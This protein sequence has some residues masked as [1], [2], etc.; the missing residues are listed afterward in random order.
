MF[1]R[2]AIEQSV[3]ARFEEQVRR[4][5][6]R[7][8][9][10][11]GVDAWSY[12][13]LNARANQVAHAILDARS[14]PGETVAL[15]L[16]QGAGLVATILG[17]LKAG[18]IYVPLDPSLAPGRLA[19]LVADSRAPL[20]IGDARARALAAT[21]R[22]VLVAAELLAGAP[23]A[24]PGLDIAP[25]AGAYV[26]YTSGSTGRPKGVLDCHRNVLHNVM[27]Y[28][29]TLGITSADRLTLLQ[30]PAF[31]GAVSSLFAALLN[32][33]ASFPY[34]VPRNGVRGIAAWLRRGAITI[35]HSVPALFRQVVAGAEAFPDLRLVRLEGDTASPRDVELFRRR[36]APGAV[37][38]NGLGATECGIVRQLFVRDG[39]PIPARLLPVGYPVEDMEVVLIDDAGQECA[40]GEVGEIAVRSRYLATGYWQRPD[41]TAA[42][43]TTLR[44]G[45]RMYRTGDLGRMTPDG[46]LTHLGR[47]DF[48]AKIRG[49]RVEVAD[50]EAALLTMPAVKDA[51]VTTLR[52]GE[53]EPRLVAYVVP[54]ARVAPTASAL[55]RHLA[56]R[57]PDVMIPAAFVTLDRLPL[58]ANG[59]V[60][61]RE[62][63]PP[64]GGRPALDR[65]FA[66]PRSLL[67]LELARIW[68]R[69]LGV[70]PVGAHD[71]FFDLGGHSL[72]AVAVLEDIERALG[73]AVSPS[74][75]MEGST[76]ALLADAI[77]REAA[78]LL[79][80]AVCL[81]DGGSAPPF[82]F[83][84]GDYLSGGLFCHGLA[85]HFGDGQAVYALPPCGLDGGSV[86]ASYEAMARRHV[87][88]IRAIQP[89][90]PY[91]LGGLCNGG[92]IAL[93]TARL[94]RGRGEMVDALVVVAAIARRGARARRLLRGAV[95]AAG[96]GPARWG[97][98]ARD[99]LRA[100]AET[101]SASARLRRLYW[102]ARKIPAALRVD[103]AAAG[104][105][106]DTPAVM[107]ARLR[108]QY[109]RIDADYAPARYEGAVTV[110]W[111]GDDPIAPERAAR[112]W[113]RRA[114]AV[115]LH[116]L[117][118]THLTCLTVHAEFAARQIQR[119]LDAATTSAAPR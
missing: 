112:L 92:L 89:R 19:E 105:G 16:D 100:V 96:P 95:A 4:H 113:S 50:V 76:V 26:Y 110:L 23:A 108:E 86:P 87:D 18:K 51:A 14:E 32:G 5:P 114:A 45:L 24:D 31:S 64:G 8:A 111:P 39:T 10:E 46:C 20:V 88:A 75:L 74:I 17:A 13:E 73:R 33:G 58:D 29:R 116:V 104:P 63:P 70:R 55:R 109:L 78:D 21:G 44:D 82:F 66:E 103:A 47:K 7:L 22:R 68:E 30:G 99:L 15:V 93:E 85:R 52:H 25:T 38:V 6:D 84:H 65:A 90:G 62:L 83:F 37:L 72:L 57:L 48:Q 11:C 1:P 40:P 107:R 118:G 28:T 71:D 54:A 77:Q 49:Q 2:A 97:R 61:R 35:Y 102:E 56:A 101:P 115:E 41:L 60:A 9:V 81:R 119:R 36:L 67:E 91:R 59:K 98:E 3:P 27:R 80:P 106:R 53:D 79:A 34:D 42:A 69:R 43:F 117:P 94:L 12:A